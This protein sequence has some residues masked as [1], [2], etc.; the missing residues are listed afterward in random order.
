MRTCEQLIFFARCWLPVVAACGRPFSWTR[1]MAVAVAHGNTHAA[2]SQ[3]SH[4]PPHQS[5]HHSTHTTAA[6]RARFCAKFALL[7]I[8][9]P[10]K[11]QSKQQKKPKSQEKHMI[12]CC[13]HMHCF[14]WCKHKQKQGASAAAHNNNCNKISYTI[15]IYSNQRE[16]FLYRLL[17]VILTASYDFLS[18]LLWRKTGVF[19]WTKA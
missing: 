13:F 2:L 6:R 8:D 3:H 18:I 5:P 7:L 1:G 4:A 17:I 15:T 11:T 19:S 14:I 12:A 10:H 9:A 16:Y